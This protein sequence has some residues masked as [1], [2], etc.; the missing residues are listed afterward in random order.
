M[1]APVIHIIPY[2]GIGGVEQAAASAEGATGNGLV[3]R[4][5][6]VFQNVVDRRDRWKTF[7]PWLFWSAAG[8]LVHAEPKLVIVSLWRSVIVMWLSKLR[9]CRAPAVLFLHNARDA[10]LLDKWVTRIAARSAVAI[11]ADSEATLE[12]R[13]ALKSH[14]PARVISYLPAK[15]APVRAASPDPTADFI[16]WGR[17]APQKDLLTALQ[18]FSKIRARAPNATFRIIGPDGGARDMVVDEIARLGL[19][20]C[21]ELLGPL[22]WEEISSQAE[23]CSFYLQTSRYEGMALSVVEAMQA[24]LV[25]VVTPVGEISSY[26]VEGKSAIWLGEGPEEIEKCARN[27]EYLIA[28]PEVW[29][30]MRAT[31]IEVWKDQMLYTDD[32]LTASKDV[33]QKIR[34]SG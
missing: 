32:V 17:L 22:R 21:T 11:W 27:I 24:G 25:P 2:D 16:F 10:H 31:T 4:R 33:L 7:N 9:G 30:E 12:Q 6:F 19:E 34:I 1:N 20:P 13:L 18:L 5:L 14:V 8:R 23:R 15:I 28:Q 26:T 3:M 29:R